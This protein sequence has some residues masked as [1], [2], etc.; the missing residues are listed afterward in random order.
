[1]GMNT[2]KI[3]NRVITSSQFFDATQTPLRRHISFK[4]GIVLAPHPDLPCHLV[5]FDDG[6]SYVANCNIYKP[7]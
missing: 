2:F 5:K 1:M 7:T 4:S 3:G 6:N